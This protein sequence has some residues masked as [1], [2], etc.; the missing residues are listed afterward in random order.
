MNS[1]LAQHSNLDMTDLSLTSTHEPFAIVGIGC[2]A[3]LVPKPGV[4]MWFQVDV[5][6]VKSI[7]VV[8]LSFRTLRRML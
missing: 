1:K 8:P 6:K 4:K 3:A 5:M 2:R 7:T